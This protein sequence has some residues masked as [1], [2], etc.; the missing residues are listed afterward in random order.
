MASNNTGRFQWPIPPWNADWQKWQ[1]EFN[2]FVQGVDATVFAIMEHVTVLPRELPIVTLVVVGPTQ[3]TFTLAGTTRFIS[4][5]T[6][7][8]ITVSAIPLTIKAENIGALVCALIQPGAV[9]PQTVDWELYSGSTPID[10][11]IVPFG[12]VYDDLSILWYNGNR[13]SVGVP[14]LLFSASGVT[15]GPAF[16]SGMIN[17]NGVVPALAGTSYY[18]TVAG[19]IYMNVDNAMTWVVT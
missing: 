7:T 15:G 16:M 11:T 5:T 3:V 12:V 13:L 14:T 10:P 8:E 17:P 2:N 18:D 9:G 6:Q 4:R 19:I 1:A